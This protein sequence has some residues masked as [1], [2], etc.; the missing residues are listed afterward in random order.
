MTELKRKNKTSDAQKRAIK[1]YKEEKTDEIRANLP[2]GYGKKLTEIAVR[3]GT[4]KARVLKDAI[5]FAYD[6]ILKNE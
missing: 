5:D 1:R 6:E 3:R 4:S 2:R